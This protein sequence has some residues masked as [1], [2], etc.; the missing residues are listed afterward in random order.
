MYTPREFSILKNTLLQRKPRMY[1]V[2]LLHPALCPLPIPLSIISKA[3]TAT[4]KFLHGYHG[5]QKV[6]SARTRVAQHS[7]RMRRD[8]YACMHC[9]E[10]ISHLVREK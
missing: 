10:H 1:Q 4:Q 9:I 3:C 8:A 5:L 2:Q 6:Y 7:V